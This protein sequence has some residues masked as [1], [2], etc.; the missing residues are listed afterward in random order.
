V[1]PEVEGAGE[2][3]IK[4]LA[5]GLYAVARCHGVPE[6]GATWQALLAWLEESP[7]RHGPHQWLEECFDPPRDPMSP[8]DQ[9][10]FD[11]YLPISE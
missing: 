6:I 1:G 9:V 4:D 10:D 11:L 5:G 8:F 2:V 7:Y 3:Q